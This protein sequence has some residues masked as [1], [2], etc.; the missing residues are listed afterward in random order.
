MKKN[1]KTVIN[2]FAWFCIIIIALP[3]CNSNKYLKVASVSLEVDTS[4]YWRYKGDPTLLLG[5][6]NHAHN[7]F[8]DG[9][10]LDT[11]QI[12]PLEVIIDQMDELAAVGGNYIRC[13]LDPGGAAKRNIHPHKKNTEGLYDLTEP[14]GDFWQRL[15]TFIREAEKRD[16]II[17]IE[18]WNWHDWY[19]E[20]WKN[21]PFNPARNTNYSVENSG[22]AIDYPKEMAVTKHPMAK[23]VPG[24]P[25]YDTASE[26]TRKKYD[27]IRGYQEIYVQKVLDHTF[28]HKNVLYCMNNETG[29]KP[30]WGAYWIKYIKGEASLAGVKVMCTD[31]TNDMWKASESRAIGYYL[32]NPQIYD[33]INVSQVNNRHRDETH[34]EKIKW[35]A[36]EAKSKN[37]LLNMSKL[38]GSDQLPHPWGGWKHGDSDNAI[39]EWWRN[40]IAGVASVRFH[41][42]PHGIGLSEE[43]KAC[44]SATREIE[45]II[46]FWNVSPRLDLLSDRESDEAYLAAQAGEEYILYMTHNGGGS[47]GL[48][49]EKYNGSEFNITWV[50]IDTA[51]SIQGSPISG[52]KVVTVN[53][54]DGTAH[55]VAAICK[56]K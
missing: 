19:G 45:S 43:S 33:Y 20:N 26:E 56:I 34:W 29:E 39:E 40:L 27:L 6:F 11:I 44:I 48:N 52:G 14:E 18:L 49:L 46:K 13:V 31:M 36:D 10:T 47:V 8:I 28:P 2:L 7:P 53:R 5:A 30:A 55:W 9:S 1:F 41:R 42:P 51:E 23:C 50:N 4:L 25:E 37:F 21:H 17:E 32:A 24:Q 12:D 38:Y 35:I 22:L 3:G 15:S 54:P 16:V